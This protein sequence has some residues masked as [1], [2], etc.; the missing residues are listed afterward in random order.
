MARQD[1]VSRFLEL[2]TAVAIF[3]AEVADAIRRIAEGKELPQTWIVRWTLNDNSNKRVV[4]HAL[5]LSSIRGKSYVI[6]HFGQFYSK[7]MTHVHPLNWADI[8]DAESARQLG[9]QVIVQPNYN[10]ISESVVTTEEEFERV[11]AMLKPKWVDDS[12]KGCRE[13][14][15]DQDFEHGPGFAMVGAPKDWVTEY[16]NLVAYTKDGATKFEA[17]F[18][19]YGGGEARFADIPTDGECR[20]PRQMIKEL[21]ALIDEDSQLLMEEQVALNRERKQAERNRLAEKFGFPV[22]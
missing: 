21:I 8:E 13:S 17:F 12:I 14:G 7:R 15:Q 18:S 16:S 5:V 11:L 6:P 2:A 20:I 4:G 3:S 1:L 19:N 9:M 10:Q 22:N